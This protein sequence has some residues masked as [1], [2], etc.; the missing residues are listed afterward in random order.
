MDDVYMGYTVLNKDNL[1]VSASGMA[2][3]L[4]KE[5]YYPIYYSSKL[6]KIRKQTWLLLDDLT[7][8]TEDQWLKYAAL[9]FA[10]A[11]D[12]DKS[13]IAKMKE[14]T[15]IVPEMEKSSYHGKDVCSGNFRVAHDALW[16][17]D[18]INGFANGDGFAL[19]EVDGKMYTCIVGQVIAGFYQGE[20]YNGAILEKGSEDTK[21]D[22]RPIYPV[23]AWDIAMV[24]S[25][26]K[27][28]TVLKAMKEY[29][30]LTYEQ[31]ILPIE[32]EYNNAL[33]L[34]TRYLRYNPDRECLEQF[35][36]IYRDWPELDTKGMLGKVDQMLDGIKV[37]DA[38]T[39]EFDSD[40]LDYKSLFSPRLEWDLDAATKDDDKINDAIRIAQAKSKDN[41][42]V[43]QPFYSEAVSLLAQ[44][45]KDFE[46]HLD[47]A[48]KAYAAY[49]EDY[50]DEQE[51]ISRYSAQMCE[52]CKIDGSKTTFPKG[53]VK[54]WEG[55]F[56][57]SPGESEED[58]VITLMNGEKIPWTF[59][60]DEN[61]YIRTG[62][63]TYSDT[64]DSVDEMI[65]AIE[66]KCKQ[67]WCH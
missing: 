37:L 34:N 27:N 3:F 41:K 15:I 65:K 7:F 60:Y 55:I 64:Y 47:N 23:R 33:M 18:V 43:F 63:S 58:G 51:R 5:G 9:V 44:R 53:Y 1:E 28:A 35:V 24:K 4:L 11:N 36:N 19:L 30:R 67:L 52:K 57:S 50:R 62:G 31:N 12:V 16:T 49:L 66:K 32:T 20:R 29:A 45:K 61:T 17:G 26:V 48:R 46:H 39:F 38:L 8:V 6:R 42:C 2:K 54:G 10:N 56:F 40:Y 22:R 59:V 13:E 14:A 21:H 25:K